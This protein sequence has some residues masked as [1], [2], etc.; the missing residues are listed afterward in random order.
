MLVTKRRLTVDEANLHPAMQRQVL[1]AV[2]E[3]KRI[4]SKSVYGFDSRA[5][6]IL[7]D[8][9]NAV[10]ERARKHEGLV[11]R[12]SAVH[13]QTLPVVHDS[14]LAFVQPQPFAL[15]STHERGT[16]RFVASG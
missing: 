16:L 8:Q 9:D 11:S 12:E 6:P 13:E 14:R 15:Q 1:H 7:V 2:I 4:A 5:D 3:Q 10:S